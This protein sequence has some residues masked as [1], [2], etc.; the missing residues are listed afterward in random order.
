MEF[1]NEAYI[2]YHAMKTDWPC[3]SFDIIP[4]KLG[5]GRNKVGV[6]TSSVLAGLSPCASV[7]INS[8]FGI[9]YTS[10]HT[11]PKQAAGDEGD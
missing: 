7:P 5:L 8:I 2:M 1:S 11:Q 6:T 3:L 10:G 9:W 4:D